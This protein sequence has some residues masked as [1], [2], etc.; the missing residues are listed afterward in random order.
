MQTTNLV[1]GASSKTPVGSGVGDDEEGGRDDDS[2]VWTSVSAYEQKRGHFE[3]RLFRRPNDRATL[4]AYADFLFEGGEHA[5]AVRVC[6][7]D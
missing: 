2:S 6:L 4:A 7:I 3:T 5:K 1:S